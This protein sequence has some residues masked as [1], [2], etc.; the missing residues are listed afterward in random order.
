M[1]FGRPLFF[2]STRIKRMWKLTVSDPETILE[3]CLDAKLG[4]PGVDF[5]PA[6][7]HEDW[8]DAHA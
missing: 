4:E 3:F 5:W 1:L 2:H 7:V 8:P 6:S